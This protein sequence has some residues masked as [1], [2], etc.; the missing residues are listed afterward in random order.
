MKKPGRNTAATAIATAAIATAVVA[1]TVPA[2]SS[3][4]G[5]RSP[6]AL[7]GTWEVT[8]HPAS[9]SGA[10]PQAPERA[11]PIAFTS[12]LQYGSRGGVTEITTRGAGLTG[13]LGTWRRG[14][15]GTYRTVFEKYRFDST[16]MWVATIRIR[17]TETVAGNGR[18][19]DGRATTDV[20]SPAGQVQMS[21]T[22]T[23]HAVPLKH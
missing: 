7:V 2:E 8:V 4:P 6:A 23:T 18:S 9:A 15:H 3:T 17:E 22:S 11:A 14:P 12:L 19:Y 5:H 1:V 10:P 16:G 13:G 20:L 21:F